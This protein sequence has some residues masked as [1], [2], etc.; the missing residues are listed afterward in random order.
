M[1]G[2]LSRNSYFSSQTLNSLP[3]LLHTRSIHRVRGK[4]KEKTG[5]AVLIGSTSQ[6][7]MLGLF[8]LWGQK[9]LL[10]LDWHHMDQED[11]RQS[12]VPGFLL[13]PRSIPHSCQRA[14]LVTIYESSFARAM[15]SAQTPKGSC[16]G[17]PGWP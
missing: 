10:T 6:H 4:P 1:P 5:S 11:L 2:L 15:S 12:S 14:Q 7:T 3:L 16:C 13:T 8:L 17:V 9:F